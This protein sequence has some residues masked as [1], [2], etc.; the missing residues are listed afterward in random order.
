MTDDNDWSLKVATSD[1]TTGVNKS[2][3]YYNRKGLNGTLTKQRLKLKKE[4]R[5]FSVV[6]IED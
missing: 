6:T 1:A 2:Y 3:Y 5:V 4:R